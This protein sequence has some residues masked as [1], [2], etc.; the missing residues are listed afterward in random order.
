MQAPVDYPIDD[1]ADLA[2]D[3]SPVD[4][5]TTSLN[6]SPVDIPEL[7]YASLLD[8]HESAQQITNEMIRQACLQMET[9]QQFPFASKAQPKPFAA[10][11][12]A[13]I[14]NHR[15]SLFATQTDKPLRKLAISMILAL[16]PSNYKWARPKS[17]S[18]L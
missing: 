18:V 9:A 8:R 2:K 14:E 3:N 1:A 6:R 15:H 13:P 17:D 12:D 5:G 11:T 10:L 16:A 7:T 4:N